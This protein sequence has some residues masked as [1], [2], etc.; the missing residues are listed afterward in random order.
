MG[1]AT[2]ANYASNY[3]NVQGIMVPMTRRVFAYDEAG[4]KIEEPVLV[5][6]DFRNVDFST[7]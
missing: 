5:T 4:R 2:G 1:G 7:E 3:R 6:I